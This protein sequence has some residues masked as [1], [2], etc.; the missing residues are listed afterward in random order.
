MTSYERLKAWQLCHR[1]VLAV[2]RVTSAF[3]TEERYGLTSQ[4]RRA[5][6]SAAANIAEGSAKRGRKEFRRYLN[7]SLGSLAE[8]AYGLML[9]RELSLLKDETWAEVDGLRT[10]ASQV[11]W[12]LYQSLGRQ[13]G[14]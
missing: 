14:Q 11:T 8:V 2:Y 12:R 10:R 5:A 13:A 4:T 1:L 7:I 6:F 3:P 9:A